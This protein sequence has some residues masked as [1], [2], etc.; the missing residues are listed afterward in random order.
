MFNL[1]PLKQLITALRSPLPDN[2][3]WDFN[4]IHKPT[5]C[6][7][8]GCALGLAEELGLPNRCNRWERLTGIPFNYLQDIFYGNVFGGEIDY[9]DIT[10]VMIADKLEEL[11]KECEEANAKHIHL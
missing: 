6:G 3:Q 4:S 10:P 2:F 11:M 1:T 7:S 9:D 5:P 8:A